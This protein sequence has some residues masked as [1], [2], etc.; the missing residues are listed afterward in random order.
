[1][2]K[3]L[4]LIVVLSALLIGCAKPEPRIIYTTVEVVKPVYQIPKFTIPP[5]PT[6]PTNLLQREDSPSDVGKAYVGTVKILTTYSNKLV[7]ILFGI[8]KKDDSQ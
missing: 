5:K 1:M 7:N 8:Q 2:K 3:H 6:L 4:I